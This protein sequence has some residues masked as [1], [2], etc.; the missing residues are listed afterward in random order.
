VTALWTVSTPDGIELPE[1]AHRA[2]ERVDV[3]LARL[4]LLHGKS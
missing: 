3:E 4:R 1:R 2:R